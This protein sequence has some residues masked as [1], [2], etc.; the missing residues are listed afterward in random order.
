MSA[1]ILIIEDSPDYL[2]IVSFYLRASGFIVE[3][4]Q[5]GREGL[6]KARNEPF[7]LIITDL[8]LPSHSSYEICTML[9]QDVRF[10]RIPIVVLT[11]SKL[12]AK[13][14]ELAKNCGADAFCP[15]STEPRKLVEKLREL[16]AAASSGPPA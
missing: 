2:E 8:M 9:R 11:A 1:R 14:E 7:D 4:A 5:D 12:H 6:T 15:K 3:T 16:I 13:D 10:Q